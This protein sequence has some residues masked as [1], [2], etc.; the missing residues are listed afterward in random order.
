MVKTTY[1]KQKNSI[2]NNAFILVILS[3]PVEYKAFLKTRLVL[4][5]SYVWYPAF[6]RRS[7]FYIGADRGRKKQ[8]TGLPLPSPCSRLPG[9][10]ESN[11]VPA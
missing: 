6:L 1:P 3:L 9:F 2:I 7:M 8:G 10:E 11:S 4:E 5:V